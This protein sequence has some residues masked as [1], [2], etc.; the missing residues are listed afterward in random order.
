MERIDLQNIKHSIKL[1]SDCPH[2][3]PNVTRDTIFYLDGEPLGFYIKNIKG[4]VKKFAAICNAEFKSDR[5]PKQNMLRTNGEPALM[6]DKGI[7]EVQQYCTILGGMIP[8]PHMSRPYPS[9]N[10][11]HQHK[12]AETFIKAMLLT[13]RESEGILKK[14]LPTIY[15]KQT[16][17]MKNVP[18][19]WRFGKLFTSSISNY[20]ISAKYHTDGSNIKGAVNIIITKRFDSKGGCLSIPDYDL[21]IECADNS[22]IVYPAYKNMHGVTPIEAGSSK[23][24]RNTFIFFALQGFQNYA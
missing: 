2:I 15:K 1:G 6:H 8:K 11:T 14:H 10:S 19:K 17:L 20:N 16:E 24:Y 21:A 9:M 23:G 22:M 3:K 7:L 18:E 4:M 12:G 5:V 13:C